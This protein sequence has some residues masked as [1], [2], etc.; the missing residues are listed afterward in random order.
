MKALRFATPL[1]FFGICGIFLAYCAWYFIN[2]GQRL[3]NLTFV[4]NYTWTHPGDDR[5]GGFSGLEIG[6]DGKTLIALSDHPALYY[7]D[8]TRDEAGN[9]KDITIQSWKR[10]AS[11]LGPYIDTLNGD[12]EGLALTAADG[13]F[14]SLEGFHALNYIFPGSNVVNWIGLPSEMMKMPSNRGIEA[15]ALDKFGRPLLIREGFE[16]QGDAPIYRFEG[17]HW[18]IPYRLAHAGS[19]VPVGAD[20]G[21]DGRLYILERD[22]VPLVGFKSQIRSFALG[23]TQLEDEKLLLRSGLRDY[24]NLEGLSVWQTPSGRIR[25]TAISDD[26]FNWFQTTQVVEFE[27]PE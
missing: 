26:N 6:A 25:L 4:S 10:L 12:T 21:P 22:Y 9:F 14:L 16:K 11:D 20:L 5:F 2:R 17:D 1:A 18:T 8:I 27:L 3:S 15:L 23:E 24:D 7:A 19:F 13:L